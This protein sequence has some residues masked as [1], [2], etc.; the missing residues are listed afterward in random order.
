MILIADNL[1]VTQ[2]AIEGAISDLNPKPIQDLVL[3]CQKAGAHMIDINAGPLPRQGDKKMAFLVNSVQ[4][5]C[6]LPLLLDT[7]NPLAIEAGLDMALMNILHPQTVGAARAG[8]ALI[9]GKPFAW[10]GW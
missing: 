8:E 6:E 1:Q 9:G 7:V 4:E 3:A 2:P 5:V 10:D